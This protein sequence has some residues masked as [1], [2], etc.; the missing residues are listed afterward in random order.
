MTGTVLPA[1]GTI[2]GGRV[3]RGEHGRRTFLAQGKGVMSAD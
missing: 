1:F 3:T 2:T